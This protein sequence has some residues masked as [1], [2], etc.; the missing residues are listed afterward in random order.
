ML[1]KILENIDK[2]NKNLLGNKIIIISAKVDMAQNK[3]NH[4][5]PKR[6][7]RGLINGL[8]TIIKDITGNLDNDDLKDI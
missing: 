2:D 5:L 7:K 6:L 4:I 1:N 8:G 3:F